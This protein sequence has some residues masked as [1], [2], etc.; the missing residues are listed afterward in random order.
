MS[1]LAITAATAILG[2]NTASGDLFPVV[3]VSASTPKGRSITRDELGTAMVATSAL[4]TAL[5]AKLD[6]AGGTMTG[7]LV[8][9]TNGAAST[10][11]LALT[12]TPFTGGTATT[13]KP[14]ALLETTGATSNNWSTSGT[15]LG[16][17]APSGFAGD[18]LS[19]QVN[20]TNK[21]RITTNGEIYL[22]DADQ[23]CM[24]YAS[25]MVRFNG[26]ASFSVGIGRSGNIGLA[27]GAN[28]G[29]RW[30][31]DLPTSW[32]DIHLTR[33]TASILALSSNEARTSGAALELIEQTAPSA[34]GS[35]CVRIYAVD[36]GS[37]KTRLMAL[38]PTGAA[39]QIAI[40]P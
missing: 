40:E 5:A 13:T 27:L 10:P 11:V 34:P 1:D 15:M 24:T 25:S 4:T 14:L 12:G 6:K 26:N 37:G 18:L 33:R 39:Q 19:S 36:N 35:N 23:V 3:D 31:N 16:V 17:N 30:T 20:A 38:F 7:A 2:S 9:S 28:A 22:N 8:N 21:C 29:M 32:A